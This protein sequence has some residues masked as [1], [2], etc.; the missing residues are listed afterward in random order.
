[1]VLSKRAYGVACSQ[2]LVQVLLTRNAAPTLCRCPSDFSNR[3]NF[4]RS[5]LTLITTNYELDPGIH[6]NQPPERSCFRL[7]CSFPARF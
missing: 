3:K 4:T 2:K 6:G 5:G 1:M 7:R